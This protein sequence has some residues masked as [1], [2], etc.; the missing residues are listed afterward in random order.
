VTVSAD[1]AAPEEGSSGATGGAGA[2]A[3]AE[4]GVRGR[5]PDFFIIGHEKC[6]TTALDLMLKEHPQIFLPDVKEQRFFAPELRGAKGNRR[7]LDATRPH[8]FERYREVFAAAGAEQLV[9]EAS[10]QY[11]RSHDAARRIAEVRPDARMIAILRE[12]ASFLRSYHLQWVQNSVES[13]RDFAKALALEPARRR[14][15]RIPRRC[16]VPQNLF[17]SDHVRYVEQL[18][19]FHAVFPAGQI[20]V[21]IYD[22]FRRDNAAVVREVLR[23]LALDETIPIEPIETKPLKSVRSFRLK[24]LAE[25]ARTAR[26]NPAAASTFGRTVNA[27]TPRPL[28]SEAFRSRWRKL[29]YKDAALPDQELMLQLRRR[30]K[31][32]VV[33]LSGYLKRDLVAEWGYDDV[34]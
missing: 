16:K 20:L 30:F 5:V 9:G 1:V 18:Q 26:Q 29:V 19:R 7:G 22:D 25:L 34:D 33:A 31:P 2:G 15:T 21:L 27:L 8:T 23:F 13:Q 28:R 10:P 6:G 32:E 3:A 12:P 24:H 11:L 17:Y 14:G 4:L